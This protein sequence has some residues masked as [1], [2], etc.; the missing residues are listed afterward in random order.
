MKQLLFLLFTFVSLYC[1]A[2]KPTQAD[3]EKA[4]RSSWDRPMTSSSP[5]QVAT[6]HTIRIGTGA[7]ANEQDIIDGIPPNATVTISQIDFTVRE[8]F[9]DQTMA[10]RRVMNAKVYK[11]QFD[12]WAVKSNG[13]KTTETKSEPKQ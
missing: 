13:M 6:I 4:L 10:T 2:Q 5:K 8:Y 1:S 7:K 3:I 11:D 9:N 12:E